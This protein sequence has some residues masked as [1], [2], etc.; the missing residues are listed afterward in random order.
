MLFSKKKAA[1]LIRISSLE[2]KVKQ[3]ECK[4][5]L[6]YLTFDTMEVFSCSPHLQFVLRCWKCEKIIEIYPDQKSYLQA[7]NEVMKKRIEA[8]KKEINKI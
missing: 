3:L 8:N 5:E 7:Q 6:I 2:D 4:H 1:L